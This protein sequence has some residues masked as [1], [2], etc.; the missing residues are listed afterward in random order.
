MTK[1]KLHPSVEQFKGFVKKNPKI[2][3]EVRAE[4]TTWQALYEE[5]YL[6][7][8]DDSRW[9]SFRAE[10]QTPVKEKSV[11]EDTKSD[12]MTNVM[13]SL[14]KMDTNQVQGYINNLN[15]ALTAVQGVI[16]QFQGGNQVSQTKSINNPPSNPFMFKKD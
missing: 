7:G 13:N 10:G 9:D 8:E 12:W 2:I 4:K 14:K 15:Q 6:F 3:Q 16:A 11:S 5:W 1:K